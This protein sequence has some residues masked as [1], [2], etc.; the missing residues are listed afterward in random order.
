MVDLPTD[1]MPVPRMKR[2]QIN[3]APFSIRGTSISSVGTM[4]RRSATKFLDEPQ[5]EGDVILVTLV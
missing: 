3:D 2:I 4:Q 1:G 5:R